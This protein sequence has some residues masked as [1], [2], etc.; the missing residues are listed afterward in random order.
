MYGGGYQ[1]LDFQIPEQYCMYLF[2]SNR[3]EDPAGAVLEEVPATPQMAT[4]PG[5]WEFPRLP[6]Q[7]VPP[8]TKM[9]ELSLQEKLP[10][11][12]TGTSG[13]Q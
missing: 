1:V 2:L 8:T 12:K 3:T 7:V 11:H 5:L 13:K 10:V 6:S 4:Q 9:A